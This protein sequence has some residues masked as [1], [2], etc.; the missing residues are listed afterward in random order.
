MGDVVCAIR[1]A[2]RVLRRNA[3]FTAMVVLVLALGI[4]V[5]TAVFSVVYSVLLKPL[6]YRDPGRLVVALHEGRFPVSPA[7]FLDYKAQVHAFERLA[8]AQAWGGT[9][10]GADQ[11]EVISGLQVTAN[12]VPMLGIEPLFGRSFTP[13]EDQ[14]G[15]RRV[16][17]LSYQ[18]WRRRFGA[19]PHVVGQTTRLSDQDYVIVGVMPPHFQF[20]PFWQ[21]QAEMWTPLM[22]GR[23]NN[24]R[25]GRSLR[26]FAR[27][28]PG[29][30]IAQAQGQ[31]DTVARRLAAAY[32]STNAN[33]G[34]ELV[35]LRE[36]V[37]GAVRPTL[38]LLLATVAFVL[39]IACAD[40]TNLVLTRAMARKKDIAVRLAIGANRFQIIRQ[41]TIESLVLAGLGGSGGLLLAR[42]SL[43]MLTA[44][45]PTASLPRQ[46]EVS[47]DAAVFGFALLV[48]LVAGLVCGLLPAQVDKPQFVD[49]R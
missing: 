36:K 43:A 49:P 2:A 41:L 39:I 31:M 5:N 25:E 4:G 28:R 45:L 22:L 34:I 12:L 37:V 16:L 44:T 19:D 7:V 33:L 29:V 42:L 6:P 8:A 38:L 40:I 13:E 47:L 20:A 18:L 17:L 46:Q 3:A 15:A 48:S 35:P 32:P 24:D 23:R 14:P 26:L 21:T 10:A 27:L 30:S 11:P 1:Y 9:L